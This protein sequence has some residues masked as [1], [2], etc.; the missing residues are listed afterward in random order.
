MQTFSFKN[1]H[2]KT[3]I[4]NLAIAEEQR[5]IAFVLHGLAGFKEQEHIKVMAQSLHEHGYTVV[6]FDS[7]NGL[8]ESYGGLEAVTATSNYEDLE[9][10]IAWAHT[11]P[12]YS[13]PFILA[14]HSLG[15]M[16]VTLYAEQH[17]EKVKAL[18]PISTAVSGKLLLNSPNMKQVRGAWEE[19]RWFIS[20]SKS[21]PGA[22]KKIPW[23]FMLDIQKYDILPKANLLTMPVLLVVGEDDP[24]TPLSNQQKFFKALPEGKKELHII[25]GAFHTFRSP[26]HL[27]ELK[28]IFDGWVEKL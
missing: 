2:G 16:C 27:A 26:E 8:G 3:I 24:S 23:S 21:R 17:P 14:G 11:Q 15:S 13:E 18:A 5:G 22:V 4:G 12:W 1:R 6:N 9:D 10:V 25:N 19:T 20:D 28:R 7:T